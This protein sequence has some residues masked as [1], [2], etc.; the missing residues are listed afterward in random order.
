MDTFVDSSWYFARFT[1]PRAEE[2]TI[3]A[4]ADKWLPVDQ[5]IGGVEHA[6]LHLLYSRFFARAMK[7]TGHLDLDEPFRGLF[8]QG[9]V[10]HETYRSAAG[11]WL[12]PGEVVVEMVDN[13]RQAKLLATGAPVTIGSI[14]KM[15]KSRKNVVDPDEIVA[16][17]GADT[18]R[19]FMLSDSPPERDVQW[20]E[21]GVE[22]AG[23]FLQRI[24]KLVGDGIAARARP[25]NGPD[26]D[27]GVTELRKL[28][29]RTVDSV[30][31]EIEGLRFNRAVA[32]IYELANGLARFAQAGEAGFS[33][34]RRDAFLEGITVLVQLVAPMMPHL[35]ETCWQALG[36]D[37]LV[38][39]APWPAVDPAL[40]VEDSVT[41]AVQVNGKLR[42]TLE[43][44]RGL[45]RGELEA[46]A[47][48]LE[49]VIKSLAGNAPK[50]VIIVPDRIVNVVV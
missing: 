47:L 1:A 28:A 31:R 22:G 21:A 6:I 42:G 25:A 13:V 27:A 4:V 20:T 34:A 30:G 35:A 41:L 36:R 5:Y 23:R 15:S 43:V 46:K 45:A 9:M 17:Y 50:K 44:I 49:P 39:D 14:E 8:T 29:H 3:P 32:Q 18:A 38:A 16:T 7:K 19:W 24:W 33:A 37:G 11:D 10:T 26:A 40:L 12:S 48:A 2:P